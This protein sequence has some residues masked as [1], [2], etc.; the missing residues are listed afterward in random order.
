MDKEWQEYNLLQEKINEL[1]DIALERLVPESLDSYFREDR[2][3]I[4]DRFLS[5]YAA[6]YGNDFAQKAAQEVSKRLGDKL[7]QSG[8]DKVREVLVR[9]SSE[10]Y[11]NK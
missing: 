6:I 3:S 11:I 5:E 9:Y 2:G 8:W 4:I 7:Q 10:K 1:I